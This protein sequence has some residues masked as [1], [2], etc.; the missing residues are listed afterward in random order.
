MSSAASKPSAPKL[1]NSGN[2]TPP[3]SARFAKKP[4]TLTIFMACPAPAAPKP[5]WITKTKFSAQELYA[6]DLSNS[7]AFGRLKL[8]MD[9]W[10]ALWF[11]PIEQAGDLPSREEWLFELESLL[12]GDTIGVRA[13][14]QHDLFASTQNPEEGKRFISQHGVVDTQLLKQA[15]PRFDLVEQLAN[16]H[17]FFHWTLQFADVFAGAPQ[18]G[19]AAQA[20]DGGFDL[21]LGNPP[22]LQVNWNSSAVLGDFEPLLILRKFSANKAGQL[23]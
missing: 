15:F 14:E 10:C 18:A 6:R 9:Y 4:A 3:S 22:W 11:W 2:C 20:H 12:L 17:K 21:M 19:E 16:Q 23:R 1:N 13:S 8:A 7:S 5:V